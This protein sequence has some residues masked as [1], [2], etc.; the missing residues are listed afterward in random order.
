MSRVS[1]LFARKAVVNG[2]SNLQLNQSSIQQSPRVKELL[3]RANRFEEIL[4]RIIARKSV[5][6]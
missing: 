6:V 3:L 5:F 1:R 4:T 2:S